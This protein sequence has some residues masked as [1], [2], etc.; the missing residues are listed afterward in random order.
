MRVREFNKHRIRGKFPS[1]KT[2]RMVYWESLNEEGYYRI[3]DFD[4]QVTNYQEQPFKIVYIYDGKKHTYT[5][6]VYVVRK[7]IRQVVEVKPETELNN[8][9]N[10]IKFEAAKEYCYEQGL[11][12]KV[13]TDKQIF[14]GELVAN[15]KLLYRYARVRIP[16][17][18]QMILAKIL[19]ALDTMP[20]AEI[21]EMLKPKL[22][23]DPWP[24]IC[25]LVYRGAL[26]TDLVDAPFNLKTELK[27]NFKII[28]EESVERSYGRN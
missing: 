24:Y 28:G 18:H 1:I 5:P 12:F 8:T 15:L 17:Q 22:G 7:D 21:C 10:L 26:T 3:L 25:G 6:D 9:E 16:F 13:V 20:V 11:E 2:G 4:P 23:L 27:S 14:K 19:A